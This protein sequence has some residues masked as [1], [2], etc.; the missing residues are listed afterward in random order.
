MPKGN[1]SCRDFCSTIASVMT[2]HGSKVV[3]AIKNCRACGSKNIYDV[4]SLG[5]IRVARFTDDNQS[6]IEAPLTFS[7]CKDCTY[8]QL[9]HNID[10]N[11]VFYPEYGYESGINPAMTKELGRIVK[12]TLLPGGKIK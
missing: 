5:S 7:W 8:L 3:V 4:F 12:S 1:L 6:V 2:K 9:R 10:S 11:L